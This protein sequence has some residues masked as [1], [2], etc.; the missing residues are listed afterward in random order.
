MKRRIFSS[1][2]LLA[3]GLLW[4]CYPGGPDYYDELDIVYTNYDKDYDFASKGTFSIPDKIVKITGNLVDGEEPEYVKDIYATPILN[5]IASNLEDLGWTQVEDPAD[6]DVQILP[7]SWTNTTIYYY[8]GDYWCW[9][10]PYYCGGYWYYPYPVTTSYTTGT[11]VI[12]MN[13]LND[14]STDGS[15][16]IAW[17]A[18]IN[19]LLSGAYD[20]DRVAKGIDQAFA[21]S[22]YLKT[23]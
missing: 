10:Y 3:F 8:Y 14:E 20:A 19:G 13:D 4:G 2:V 17:T 11:L 6:A 22:P 7:A 21:Q 1:A 12:A 15:T 16:K 5:Q 18:A 23:N 9:Y